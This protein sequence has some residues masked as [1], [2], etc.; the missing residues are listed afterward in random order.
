MN[1]ASLWVSWLSAVPY[2]WWSEQISRPSMEEYV[3]SVA[4]LEQVF[5]QALDNFGLTVRQGTAVNDLACAVAS[6]IEVVWLNQC[7]TTCHP[8]DPSEPIASLLRRAGRMLWLGATE[9]RAAP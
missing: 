5:E 4:R 8:C 7:L 6:L 9:P 3:Q 2:G 1:Y